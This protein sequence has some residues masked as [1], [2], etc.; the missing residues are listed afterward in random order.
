M[1]IKNIINIFK[2]YYGAQFL[3]EQ[4]QKYGTKG[5]N[6]R[7]EKTIDQQN[8]EEEIEV[9]DVEAVCDQKPELGSCGEIQIKTPDVVSPEA[10]MPSDP[11]G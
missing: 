9:E 11:C 3:R 7:C 1:E 5:L 6:G 10:E 2:R 8:I 4:T